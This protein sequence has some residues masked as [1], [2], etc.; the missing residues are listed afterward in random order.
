MR[1]L[2]RGRVQRVG[3]PV[4]VPAQRAAGTRLHVAAR[5]WAIPVVAVRVVKTDYSAWL[6]PERLAYEEFLWTDPATAT[7][8]HF[9]RA[10]EALNLGDA[11]SV[12]ELGCG[13]GLVAANLPLYVHYLGVDANAECIA[14]AERRCFQMSRAFV[15]ADLR[16]AVMHPRGLPAY[17]VTCAFSVLKHFGLHE[18]DATVAAVLRH[19]P[20]GVFS[21][22][23]GPADA[24]DGTEFPHVRVTAARLLNAVAGAGH[25]VQRL[26]PLP[27]GETLVTTGRAA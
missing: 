7:W 17:D 12:V 6:T 13:T 5:V 10:L 16:T 21:I 8:P 18:W 15:V 11:Y 19:A 23:L 4:P 27:W 24:D 1:D 20:R 22:P 14:R 26:E 3:G 2:E 25:V 9:V